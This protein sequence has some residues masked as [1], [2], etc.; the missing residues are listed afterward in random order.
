MKSYDKTRQHIKKQR[1]FFADK[2]LC[3]KSYGF[4]SSHV[5]MRELDHKK[6]WALKNWCFRTVVLK[7]TLESHLDC[8]GIKSVNQGNQSWIFIGR[9]DAETED[10]ILWPLDVKNWFIGTD[11]DAGKDWSW[12]EKGTT[13]DESIGCH[14]WLNGHEFKQAP[15]VG[16]GHACWHAAVH[17]VSNSW[18]WLNN[19]TELN[20]FWLLLI[21][22]L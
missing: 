1:H 17:E 22:L 7:K 19:W 6:S 10:S 5:W 8:K 2:G 20:F 16:N 4:S 11:L 21:M 13:E 3:S 9:T 18:T 15:G 14:H 12:E